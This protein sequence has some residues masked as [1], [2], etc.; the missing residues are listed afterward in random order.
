VETIKELKILVVGTSGQLGQ[1]FKSNFGE[2]IAN[3]EI[4]PRV[5]TTTKFEIVVEQFLSLKPKAIL[6]AAAWTDVDGAEHNEL[7]ANIA[8][9]EL[10][11]IIAKIAK[12]MEIPFYQISSD[13]VF[14]GKGS[15][16]WQIYDAKEPLNV[17]GES[18]SVGEE[19]AMREYI[20]G[21][22]IMRTA[23]LYSPFRKNFAKTITRLALQNQETIRVV[24]DQIGQPTS[25]K[26]LSEL[27]F[28]AITKNLA[29]G[30]YHATNSGQASWYEFAREIFQMLG[31]DADRVI[32]VPSSEM[33]LKTPRPGYS[34]LSD[35]C[36]ENTEI[37]PMRNWREA[38]A[39]SIIEIRQAVIKEIK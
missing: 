25:A 32:P 8:N 4:S 21:A 31:E 16:P 38:L 34:V 9:I 13:Y 24:S 19:L 18:K 29:P 35:S 22:R 23:W 33:N 20:D 39:E 27:L 37:V 30:I 15:K 3:V 17:Y 7:S 1:T 36:W 14:S 11:K 12:L 26:D 5:I 2:C 28:A 6:N 10:P